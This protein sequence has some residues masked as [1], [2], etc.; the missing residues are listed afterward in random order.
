MEDEGAEHYDP[1][2][3]LKHQWKIFNPRLNPTS[4][5]GPDCLQPGVFRFTRSLEA[6]VE[7][8]LTSR[9]ENCAFLA[10]MFNEWIREKSVPRSHAAL[11]AHI[12]ALL[13]KGSPGKPADPRNPRTPEE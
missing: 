7:E 1:S 11:H 13:R 12:T 9:L 10:F 2:N 5:P 8:R 3:P 4:S 6:T